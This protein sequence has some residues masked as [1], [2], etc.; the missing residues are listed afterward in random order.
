MVLAHE[1]KGEVKKKRMGHSLVTG[2]WSRLDRMR[3]VLNP[4]WCRTWLRG[5]SW[6]QMQDQTRAR[7]PVMRSR[8]GAARAVDR[9][10]EVMND[11]THGEHC[12]HIRSRR[13]GARCAEK[14]R[15]DV[16]RIRSSLT[17]HVQS[18]KFLSGCLLDTTGRHLLVSPIILTSSPVTT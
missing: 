2:R 15:P 10:Q 3:P 1:S 16:G 8:G 4:R 17:G 7:S 5:P 9:T 13:C 6:D 18:E 11:R 12:S 14:K